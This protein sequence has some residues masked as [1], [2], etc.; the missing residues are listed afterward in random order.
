MP[1]PFPQSSHEHIGDGDLRDASSLD[2]LAHEGLHTRAVAFPVQLDHGC[3]VPRDV[4]NV[5][6]QI[7]DRPLLPGGLKNARLGLVRFG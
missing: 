2:L 1:R 4:Q 5:A 3:E 7:V 6:H